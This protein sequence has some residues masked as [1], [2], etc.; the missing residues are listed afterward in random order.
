MLRASEP[1]LEGDAL[2]DKAR[3]INAA[4]MAKI[5]TVEWTPAVIAHPT[6]EHAIR[7]TWWGVL[8]EPFKKHVGRIGSGEVL[9]GIPGSHTHHDG[10][11]YSLTEEFVAVY[12]MH[13]LIPDDVAFCR[14]ADGKAISTI[15]FADLTAIPG[16]RDRPRKQLKSIGYEDALYSLGIAHPGEISLHNFPDFLRKLPQPDRVDPE[17]LGPPLDL[18][19][20]DI[21]RAREAALPHYNDFR[22]VFRLAPK[23]S[24]YELAGRNREL[25]EEI[26]RVYGDVE[27]VDL[28]IGLFAE[29]KPEGFAF[30]DTAFRVFLLMAARRL[31]SDRFFT[32][33][34]TRE[35][36]T[37]A[38]FR[39][40][41]ERTM[42]QMLAE[43]FPKLRPVLAKVS[44]PFTPWP[45][46]P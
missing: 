17:K 15:E 6:S 34:F 11:R 10:V 26:E 35:V 32:T 41:Q 25:A 43:H 8:K 28:M 38:G 45:R 2:F 1:G 3:L 36:Y 19:V 30:S 24:F 42:K 7:A 20:R 12:R 9:S 18:A 39:W 33:D 4:V 14:F 29:P 27:N 31:R 22:R 44:N 21:E 37:R 46:T 16:S 5:H 40:V 23:T 13:P